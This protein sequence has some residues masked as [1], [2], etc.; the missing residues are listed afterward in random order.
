MSELLLSLA[1]QLLMDSWTLGPMASYTFHT[2][3]IVTDWI[4]PLVLVAGA[5]S[6]LARQVWKDIVS[7]TTGS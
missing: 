1:S 4:T 2:P 5:L 7:I 3:I 6:L